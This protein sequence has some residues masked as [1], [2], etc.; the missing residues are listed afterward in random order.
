MRAGSSER[1]NSMPTDA[2]VYRPLLTPLEIPENRRV[3][4]TALGRLPRGTYALFVKMTVVTRV[5]SR[6]RDSAR[7]EFS[8]EAGGQVD[9]TVC[10]LWHS[11]DPGAFQPADTVCLQM[12]ATVRGPVRRGSPAVKLFVKAGFGILE[13]A[14]LIITAIRLDSVTDFSPTPKNP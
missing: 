13:I 2:F 14:N 11:S 9:K 6:G 4:I 1:K 5:D 7:G 12:V 10:T 8:L 3:Q